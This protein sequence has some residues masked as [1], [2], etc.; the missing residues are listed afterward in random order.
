MKILG[1][2]FLVERP[3][4]RTGCP[5]WWNILLTITIIALSN[6]VLAQLSPGPLSHPHAHLEGLKKCSHCHKLGSRDVGEKCLGCHEEIAAMRQGGSGMHAGSDFEN[7]VDCHVEHQGKEYDL[8]YW[9]E[10]PESFDHRTVGFEKTGRHAELECRQCHYARYIVDA[11]GLKAMSKNLGR[12]YLG[13]DSACTSCHTDV[14]GKSEEART[15]TSC[16]DSNA[17]RPAP[18]F[19]HE[20]TAFPLEGKHQAVDCAKCHVPEGEGSPKVFSGLSHT[21]CTDCHRDPHA[22]TL[23]ADCR[24]CHSTS[25]WFL[26]QGAAFD[27]SATRYPLQGRHAGVTCAGCHSQERKKPEFAACR[28]CHS[29]SHD[30]AGLTKPGL[31]IC[32]DCHTVEGFR[33]ARYSMEKHATTAFPL[34]GAHRATPCIAC[35][36][37][38]DA[39]SSANLAPAHDACTDCHQ[40]P[41]FGQADKF[42]AERGC[43][44]C[45]D[46]G[47]WHTVDF[48]HGATG[49][50]LEGRHT[51]AVCLDCHPKT[52]SGIGFRATPLHCAGCHQDVHRGQFAERVTADGQV[53]CDQCHV[54]VDWLAEKFNHETGSRFALKGGHERVACTGCHRPL[55]DGNDRL[56]HFKPLLTACKEC[57]VNVEGP[58]G[59]DR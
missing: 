44:S 43:R 52:E 1:E 25:G 29:D 13:L 4:V 55:E 8:I 58:G 59:D 12:T 15:C 11:S 10:G 27:H 32:E 22:G 41:H 30:S 57:H 16:H 9:P 42:M 28:D 18:L 47:S 46:Q 14:H 49:F 56:L 23:G 53:A 45:H 48:D 35:H 31:M 36:Q 51:V 37:P 50:A 21:T 38:R 26:I 2:T 24:Q 39:G 7:C 17:W 34:N 40:D 3:L 20:K 6:P 54:T 19:D 33:P 5:S